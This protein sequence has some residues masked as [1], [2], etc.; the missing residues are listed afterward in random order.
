VTPPTRGPGSDR[1]NPGDGGDGTRPAGDPPA[2]DGSTAGDG[3]VV[4]PAAVAVALR[5]LVP[6]EHGPAFWDD[7]DRRLA[8]EPQLRLAPRA[9]IRPITQPPPVIDDRKLAEH[10][11]EPR[12]RRRRSPARLAAWALAI[13]LSALLIA[14]ALQDPDDEPTTGGTDTATTSENRAP[15]SGGDTTAP[16]APSSTAPPGGIDPGAALAPDGVGPLEI[17]TPLRDLQAAGVAIT[18]DQTTFDA[19][20]GACFDAKVTGALD[21]VLRFRSPEPGEGVADPADA[22]LAAIGIDS[23]LPTTRTSNTAIGLGAPQD[24][25]L[26]TYGGNL[27]D[28]SHPY[29]PGGHIY[30]ASVGNGTG[31]GIA[32][33]TDGATV[34]GITAGAEDV[35]RYVDG[36]S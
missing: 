10:L 7:L 4:N 5:K 1:Q 36:C 26:G 9:A 31:L 13:V 29:V 34:T 33:L 3:A 18:V 20:G 11:A 15:T 21:L 17:D 6:P 19:S 30:V 14:A 16:Q 28:N 22:H 12:P 2:T 35:I 23:A 25:V 8:D 27:T 32:Y 24:Q